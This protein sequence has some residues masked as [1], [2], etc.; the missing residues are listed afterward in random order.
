MIV[1]C[2]SIDLYC[3]N[4]VEYPYMH[5]EPDQFTGET[6]GE[7]IAKA[8]RQGWIVNDKPREDG[9]RQICPMCSGKFQHRGVK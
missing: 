3:D 5:G 7:C 4:F 9:G 2:Y 1:G 6:R 8:R